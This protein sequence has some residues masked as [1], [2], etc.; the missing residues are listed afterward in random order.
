MADKG[1]WWGKAHYLVFRGVFNPSSALMDPDQVTGG[2]WIQLGE[3]TPAFGRGCGQRV[4]TDN[5]HAPEGG[6]V[7]SITYCSSWEPL[8]SCPVKMMTERQA[9]QPVPGERATAQDPP[10]SSDEGGGSSN[11]QQ[12]YI[13]LCCYRFRQALLSFPLS[14]PLQRRK[15]M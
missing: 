4:W 13:I 5:V 10:G 3:E 1:R 14:S 12:P 2:P 11:Y 9:V 6:S 7:P 8:D 15:Y